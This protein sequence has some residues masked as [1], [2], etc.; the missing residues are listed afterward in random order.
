MFAV[1]ATLLLSGCLGGDNQQD[2]NDF[3]AET[4]RRPKKPL[5]PLPSFEPYEPFTYSAAAL[6]SPFQQPIAEV[7]NIYFS[8][9]SNVKPDFDRNKEFLEDFGINTMKLVGFI[10]MKGVLQALID[11][12]QNGKVFPVRVGNYLGKDHGRIVEINHDTVRVVQ[13][14]SDGLSGW[15]EK[16]HVL[17]LSEKD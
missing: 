7:E 4:K 14:V 8:G 16:P 13:I 15:V 12:G 10:E 5:E 1:I 17:K 2:L 11:Y 6:R 3:I 9:N